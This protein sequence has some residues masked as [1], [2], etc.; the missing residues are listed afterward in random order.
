LEP[1]TPS[2][3]AADAGAESAGAEEPGTDGLTEEEQEL[4]E[5]LRARDAEMRRHEAAHAAAGGQYAGTPTFTYQ[6]GP[7]GRQYAIGGAVS[8]DTAPV[9]GDPEATLRKAQQI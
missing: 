8:I 5:E 4:V 3:K 6:T 2:S 9:K 1:A 7:D